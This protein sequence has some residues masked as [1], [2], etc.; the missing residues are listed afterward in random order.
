MVNMSAF[1]YS[2]LSN[3]DFENSRRGF[4]GSEGAP[5]QAS[6]AKESESAI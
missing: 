5:S 6:R 4:A 2:P 3:R 1:P